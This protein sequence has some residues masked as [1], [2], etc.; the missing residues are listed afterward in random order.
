M[1]PAD[2]LHDLA[3]SIIDASSLKCIRKLVRCVH[4][5]HA[6]EVIIRAREQQAWPYRIPGKTEAL[7]FVP[8]QRQL[9]LNLIVIWLGRVLVIVE[10][11]NFAAYGLSGNNIHALR[12]VP[13]FIHLSLMI[14]LSFDRDLLMFG[15]T[16]LC[17]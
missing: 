3:M 11:V 17:S 7:S 4:V 9:R 12:H 5:P 10:N 8:Q 15:R 1:V 14:N 13:R 2:I 16:N 6:H